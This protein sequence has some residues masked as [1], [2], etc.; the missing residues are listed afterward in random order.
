MNITVEMYPMRLWHVQ[1]PS[2]YFQEFVERIT[3][4]NVSK[5]SLMKQ[6]FSINVHVI[7]LK[8]MLKFHLPFLRNVQYY[9]ER[10]K[11]PSDAIL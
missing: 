10:I 1:I 9:H 8:T 7:K 6:F 11:S 4:F 5:S 2:I 3:V